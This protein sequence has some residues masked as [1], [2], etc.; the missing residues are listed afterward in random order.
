MVV[1]VYKVVYFVLVYFCGDFEGLG[2]FFN[3]M[4]IFVFVFV[5]GFDF[6]YFIIY[7]NFYFVGVEFV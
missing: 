1:V 3:V 5:V 2:G 4:V 6:Y 7:W